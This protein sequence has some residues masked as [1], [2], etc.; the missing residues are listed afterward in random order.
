LCGRGRLARGFSHFRRLSR[1]GLPGSG[2][3]QKK[4]SKT[5]NLRRTPLAAHLQFSHGI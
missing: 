3:Q 5:K 1:P 2:E 4:Q